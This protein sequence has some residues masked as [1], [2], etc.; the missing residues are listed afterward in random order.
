ML[1]LSFK[2]IGD[3][4]FGIQSTAWL[5]EIEV[6]SIRRYEEFWICF[7]YYKPYWLLPECSFE[8]TVESIF[9]NFKVVK[10]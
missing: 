1:I 5:S 7:V 6:K 3:C 8:G 9:F 2:T 4:I 10:F